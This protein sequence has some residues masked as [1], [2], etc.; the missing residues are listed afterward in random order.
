[1]RVKCTERIQ[2]VT[3]ANLKLVNWWW[4]DRSHRYRAIYLEPEWVDVD[5]R[6][7]DQYVVSATHN[8][9]GFFLENFE[10][11]PGISWLFTGEPPFWRCWDEKEWMI[12][13]HQTISNAIFDELNPNHGIYAENWNKSIG[14]SGSRS[15]VLLRGS[16]FQD[17]GLQMKL[18]IT[19]Q[20]EDLTQNTLVPAYPCII[21]YTLHMYIL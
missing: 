4:N 2:V 9:A 7:E 11:D 1:M 21:L 16:N 6:D 3:L 20:H 15:A 13:D 18:N 8:R 10:H 17:L 14:W 19:H 12:M 5:L